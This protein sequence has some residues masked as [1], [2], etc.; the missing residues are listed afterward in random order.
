MDKFFDCLNMNNF[1]SGKKKRKVF[2]DQYKSAN[3]FRL[4]VSVIWCTYLEFCGH[5]TKIFWQHG[6]VY[7]VHEVVCESF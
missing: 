1:L 7:H 4:K 3:D 2:Q 5:Y 6:T